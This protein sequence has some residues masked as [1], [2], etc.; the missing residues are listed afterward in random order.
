[1]SGHR[2]QILGDFRPQKSRPITEERTPHQPGRYC[3]NPHHCPAVLVIILTVHIFHSPLLSSPLLSVGENL[4]GPR[5]KHRNEQRPI[6][7]NMTA[8]RLTEERLD[9][10]VQAPIKIVDGRHWSPGVY[11]NLRLM[12]FSL[13]VVW[14]RAF[15][16]LTFISQ[17]SF[18]KLH[19]STV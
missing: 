16:S 2:S 14:A 13:E 9:A 17:S 7:T 8:T 1:M 18:T 5:G 10:G 19:T 3:C 4:I 6:H 15:I 11:R 12:G